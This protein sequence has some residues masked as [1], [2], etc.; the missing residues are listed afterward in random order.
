MRG[1][2]SVAVTTL[3]ASLASHGTKLKELEKVAD[4]TGDCTTELRATV[5]QLQGDVRELQAKCEDLEGCSRWNNL[6]L[7]GVEEG[8][9]NGQ[10][11]Q[12]VS[13]LLKYVLNLSE[14][15]LLDR[16]HRSLRAKPITIYCYTPCYSPGG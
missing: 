9:E 2:L 16:A 13:Q 5:S 15:P 12:F 11:T 4:Y 3:R 8:L 7:T 10:P 6:Q 14:A 1:K